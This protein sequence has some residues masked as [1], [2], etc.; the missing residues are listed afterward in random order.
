MNRVKKPA[1]P[2]VPKPGED[3]A[4]FDR[5]IKE[6]LEIIMGRRVDEID[7]LGLLDYSWDDYTGDL[8]T[9]KVTGASQPVWTQ[10]GSTGLYENGFSASAMNECW[11]THH[12][13][14]DYAPGTLVYPHIHWK[15]TT[16]H[17]G[18]VRWGVEYSATKG[19]GQ[20]GLTSST[21]IYLEHAGRGRAW[22]HQ[23]IEC[24]DAQAI[25]ADNIEPDTLVQVRVFR[26]GGH[27]NDTYTGVALGTYCDLHYLSDG[28][29]TTGKA[30]AWKKQDFDIVRLR[31]KINEIL[32][33]LQ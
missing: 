23:I 19:H 13:K 33:R 24:S 26:D 27:V 15:P 21:T 17:N 29:R 3:R 18:V 2:P 30:P 16:T 22:M 25:V 14:H 20:Q 1:I 12:I 32:A 10:V 4:R 7:E 6:A 31:T 9:A 8:N 5:A 28:R 11:V